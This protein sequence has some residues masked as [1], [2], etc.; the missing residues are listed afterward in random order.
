[1]ILLVNVVSY[2]LWYFSVSKTTS[3]NGTQGTSSAGTEYHSSEI[4]GPVSLKQI[5]QIM[6]AKSRVGKKKP[7]GFWLT[8]LK[9]KLVLRE[10]NALPLKNDLSRQ[11]SFKR[12]LF[13]IINEELCHKRGIQVL[14]L[15]LV[16]TQH[17]HII[18]MY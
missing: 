14:P 15:A 7:M 18:F 16:G 10:F 9:G 4:H 2:F 11:W 17:I 12:G 8:S 13:Y 5:T 1:M 3:S 6:F